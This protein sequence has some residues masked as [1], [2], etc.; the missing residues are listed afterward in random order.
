MLL[1]MAET[2]NPHDVLMKTNFHYDP[3]LQTTMDRIIVIAS[4]ENRRDKRSA[5]LIK[6]N[7]FNL[8]HI[9]MGGVLRKMLELERIEPLDVDAYLVLYTNFC[10]SAALRNYT[11]YPVTMEEWYKG[12]SLIL[13]F[14]RPT[15]K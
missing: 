12:V 2:E 5:E 6:E 7:I 4:L 8:V 9:W 1:K 15:G 14:I 3:S 11:S 10:Y 13:S